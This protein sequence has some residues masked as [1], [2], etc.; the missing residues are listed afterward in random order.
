MKLRLNNG[1]Y[2]V[3]TAQGIY[4]YN[5]EFNSKKNI[6]VFGSYLVDDNTKI[7]SSDM[8]QFLSEDNGYVICLIFNETYIISKSGELLYH[9]SIDYAKESCGN[10]IIPYGHSDNNHYFVIINI[11]KQDKDIN[12]RKYIYDSSNENVQYVGK[13]TYGLGFEPKEYIS[14]ELMDYLNENVICCF[15]GEWNGIYYTVFNTS[16]FS[17]ITDHSSKINI[18]GIEGGER[19]LSDINSIT[20]KTVAC[21]TQRYNE[22][23]CFGYNIDNNEFTTIGIISD[24]KCSQEPIKIKVEF[25]PETE[26]FLIGCKD[27]DNSSRIITF[28]S[29][30]L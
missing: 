4:L 21:C 15:Y 19:F 5:D 24:N 13:I 30:F 9:F 25:F 2:L 3:M 11:N 18:D 10:Q 23:Y 22:L 27:N 17:P 26:E 28:L 20:R 16:D 8:A 12:F 1:N 7:Y 6:T 14:C 29:S